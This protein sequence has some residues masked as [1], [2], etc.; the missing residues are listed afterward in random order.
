MNPNLENDIRECFAGIIGQPRIVEVLIR[1]CQACAMGGA[2]PSYAFLGLAGLGKTY[3]MRALELAIGIALKARGERGEQRL[4]V[5][6]PDKFRLVSADESK[7]LKM[8]C[9]EVRPGALFIDEFHQVSQGYVGPMKKHL[10]N[11][12]KDALAE[13]AEK[14]AEV[15]WG[16]DEERVYVSRHTFGCSVATNY[17]ELVKDAPAIF[18]RFDAKL[19]L[20]LLSEENISEITH[21]MLSDKGIK[22]DNEKTLGQIARCGRGTCELPS[23]IATE[24]EKVARIAGKHSI[25]RAEVMQALRDLEKFPRGMDKTEMQVLDVCSSGPATSSTLALMTGKE[26]KAIRSAITYLMGQRHAI[27]R[28]LTPYVEKFGSFIRTTSK[29]QEFLTAVRAEKFVF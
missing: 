1:A 17:P 25:N 11:F 6:S 4:W 14:G 15:K 20:D 7:K 23:K 5:R 29:G 9:R 19:N 21:K 28:R 8:F 13:D 22:C 27:T 3:L 24:L 10:T 18:R 12:L 2:I 16:D 26:E